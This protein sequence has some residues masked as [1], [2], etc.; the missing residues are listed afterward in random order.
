MS[1]LSENALFL[2]TSAG[3]VAGIIGLVLRYCYKIK[4]M[5]ISLCCGLIVFKRNIEEE[6][7]IDL[8]LNQPSTKSNQPNA[9]RRVSTGTTSQ[10]NLFDNRMP[11]NV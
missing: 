7:K 2:T 10:F 3:L 11:N 6:M 1:S 9:I 4:C 8:Q 5:E